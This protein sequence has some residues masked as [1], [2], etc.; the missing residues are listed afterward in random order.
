MSRSSL[1]ARTQIQAHFGPT[2]VLLEVRRSSRIFWSSL[3]I[4]MLLEVQWRTFRRIPSTSDATIC[5]LNPWFRELLRT[6]PRF[7]T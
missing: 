6:I 3:Q 1:V 4:R 7:G 5:R 2:I